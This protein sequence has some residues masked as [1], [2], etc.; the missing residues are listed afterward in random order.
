M[1]GTYFSRHG[2]PVRGL[3]AYEDAL[4]ELTELGASAYARL[5][6]NI[7]AQTTAELERAHASDARGTLTAQQL[8]VAELVAEGYTSVEI[9]QILHV[10]SKTVDFHVGNIVRRLGV[11]SRREI[12]R[13]LRPRAR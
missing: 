13:R 9:A 10:S 11:G 3:A 4:S 5:C 8:R 7:I 1:A 6:A 12:A 2:D